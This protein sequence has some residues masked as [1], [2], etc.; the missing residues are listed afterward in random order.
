M[1]QIEYS[2]GQEVG[3]TGIANEIDA[4]SLYDKCM[5]L[6][7][8]MWWSWQPE[9]NSLFRDID[10]IRWRQLDHNPIALLREF[11][12]ERLAIRAGEMVLHSRVNYAYRRLQEYLECKNTWAQN[13]AG[14]L[15]G[16]PVAYF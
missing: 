13:N 15:G 3:V 14:V 8:N 10:P 5:A 7:R 6:A 1:T 11:T 4:D 12:P 9:V 16:K 2:L